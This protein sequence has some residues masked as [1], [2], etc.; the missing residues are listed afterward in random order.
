MKRGLLMLAVVA[1]ALTGLT[2]LPAEAGARGADGCRPLRALFYAASGS[3][4][5]AQALAAN[6]SSCAQYYVSV[7][8]LT[9]DKT[10]MR[11]G[12]A[13]PIRALGPSFH[14][15]AEVNVTAW[16]G[17]VTSNG[18]SWYQAGVEARRRMAAAGF[19]VAA[20]DT[21]AVNELSSA[22]RVGS[23]TSRQNIR[24]LV[25][26]LYD[27]DGGPPAKGVVFV[28]GIGQPT[29]SLDTYKARLESWLQDAGFWGDMGA[30]VSDYLQ[31]NY[32][33][34]RDYAVAGADVPTRLGYLN[35]YLEHVLDL[36]RSG[37]ATAASA[38]GYL[39]T[40]YAALANAAWA[41]TSG[42][43]FTAV[44]SDVMQDYVS[45]QLAAMRVYDAS[46][47]WTA[48]RI[49]FAWDPSNSLG[50]ATA[51]FNAQLAAI[52]ARLAVAIAAA[53]ACAAPSCTASVDGAAFT[54][55]WGA[56]STWS[57]TMAAFASSPQ[58]VTAGTPSGPMSVQL[59][60]GSIASSLP[61]DTAV[62]LSSSSSGG[63]F[64]ASSS[65]PW[66]PTL[67]L[68]VPA[69]ATNATFYMLD[70]Q[71]GTPTVTASL[72]GVATTQVEAVNAPAQP[73]ALG[74]GG[75]TV[76]YVLGGAPVKVDPALTVGDAASPTLASASVTLTSGLDPGDVLSAAATQ[77]IS[78]AYANGT[79]TLSG[80]APVAAYQAAL[81]S[82]VF[83]GATAS[84]G[85][86]SVLWTV[87]DGS[88]TASAVSTIVYTAPPGAP[89]G[90]SAA[91]GD[92][93]A[94]VTFGAPASDGG[95]PITVYTVT[96][97][98]GGAT[99]TGGNSPIT[100][101][102]LTNGTA[103]T[104]TV[105]ASNA[106]GT[107]PVS[108]PSNAVVPAGTGGGGGGGGAAV[109][110]ATVT[111]PATTPL[112]PPLAVP[113][114]Q[115]TPLPSPVHLFPAVALSLSG[116]EAVRLGVKHPAI[117]FTVRASRA[118]RLVLTLRDVRGDTLATWR[119]TLKPGVQKVSLP[120]ASR[121]QRAGTRRL[122]L[123]WTR[124]GP[125]TFSVT[126]KR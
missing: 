23:G 86:R 18:G 85:M 106:A 96:A 49:G 8:P 21:W 80:T 10:Q 42:F 115:P 113:P 56:F 32:G 9:A 118:A 29:G 95:T 62:T 37:P 13:G 101:G 76:T 24:D 25:H 97:Q 119:R 51:D 100:V 109:P 30:Y 104:F 99:A 57:P 94:T 68:T 78:A 6:A 36:A 60:I 98:P 114:P 48:D 26:G 50:L 4:G 15:L 77:G 14:A 28:T 71:P 92:G 61:F 87:T 90:V 75:N 31:E 69:G 123:V 105:T 3:L 46:L 2:A 41:W 93:Q 67:A 44:S 58:T 83:S 72:D 12:T 54:P 120:L 45:A 34:V 11:P 111:A 117:N 38:A 107:G 63:S 16:Q 27:G 125:K 108:T 43:G 20:G 73:L 39:A 5:L 122:R 22:V 124:G 52:Q 112:T 82:V 81:Q 66:T 121:V 70:S 7:P 110:P 102:G 33:D 103:Y 84:G 64:S 59:Q 40:S 17:W 1:A 89:A 88:I 79:L 55:A 53:D 19:D 116:L 91:A 65:G 47:G 35:A 74:S 126:L